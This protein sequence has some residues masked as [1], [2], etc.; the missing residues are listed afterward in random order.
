MLLVACSFAPVD[1]VLSATLTETPA[2]IAQGGTVTVTWSAIALPTSLD[3][4]GLYVPGAGETSFREWIYLSCSKS[5]GGAA[6]NGSCP[7]T[8]PHSLPNGT[9]ELRLYTNNGF[10][11]LATSNQFNIGQTTVT[12]PPVGGIA[13]RVVDA[14]GALVGFPIQVFERGFEVLRRIPALGEKPFLLLV[15][16]SGF[17]ENPVISLMYTSNNCTGSGYPVANWGHDFRDPWMYNPGGDPNAGQ[18]PPQTIHAGRL[19]FAAPP[20]QT[21]T[22]SSVQEFNLATNGPLVPNG[23]LNWEGQNV[24]YQVGALES[25]NLYSTLSVQAPFRLE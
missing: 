6:V 16:R 7:F 25:L 20:F 17:Q 13:L 10:T 23:C 1:K 9:Y 5:P 15:D 14:N 24:V 19:Y 11:R 22:V 8:V 4:I 3:W 18:S 21:I 12:P 2:N